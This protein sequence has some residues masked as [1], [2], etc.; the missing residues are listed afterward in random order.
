MKKTTKRPNGEHLFLAGS[1]SRWKEFLSAF[2]IMS[3]FIYGFRHLHFVGPCITVFGSARFDEKHPYYQM[4]R[5]LSGQLA[6]AGFTIMTGGGPGIMEAANRGAKE[7]GGQSVGCNIILPKEQQPNPYLDIMVE[8]DHFYV[9]KVLLV[10]YSY[11]FVVFPGGFGTMDEL[12]ETITLMQTRKIER[13]PMVLMGTEYWAHLLDQI[14]HMEAAGTISPTDR[15]LFL[16]TDS[17]SE[18]ISYIFSKLREKYGQTVVHK[19]QSRWWW[20]GEA[21]HPLNREYVIELGQ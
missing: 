11:A 17:M 5:E 15:K 20:L 13:F 19:K 9:R 1:R 8:M 3:E 14:A 7:S 2:R 12:F 16:V 21:A 10:K 4:A 18:A 6:K